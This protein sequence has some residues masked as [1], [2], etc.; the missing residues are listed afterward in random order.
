[1]IQLLS[2]SLGK[3]VLGEA[4]LRVRILTILGQPYCEEFQA[5]HVNMSCGRNQTPD[6]QL[7]IS[8]YQQ[9]APTCQTENEEAIWMSNSLKPPDDPSSSHHLIATA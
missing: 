3:C 8:S 4:S 2:D 1:M 5:T 9:S 6:G 7:Q